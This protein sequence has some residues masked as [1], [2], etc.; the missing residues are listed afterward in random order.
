MTLIVPFQLLG[1]YY[2]HH[3]LLVILLGHLADPQ[4]S[5]VG[6]MTGLTKQGTSYIQK[7][8]SYVKYVL[9]RNLDN[10]GMLNKPTALKILGWGKI[11]LH[12]FQLNK[13]LHW[14]ASIPFFSFP[15]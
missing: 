6:W 4:R 5:C 14:K 15:L 13:G 12:L 7:I 8:K 11:I 2:H 3:T 9:H 1:F 10:S